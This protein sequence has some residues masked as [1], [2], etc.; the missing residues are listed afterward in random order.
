MG[1]RQK[2]VKSGRFSKTGEKGE[3]IT[4]AIL[5]PLAVSAANYLKKYKE[6]I[7]ETDNDSFIL[8]ETQDGARKGYKIFDEM[9]RDSQ[10][11]SDLKTRKLK[12]RG[13]NWKIS[14]DSENDSDLEQ[15]LQLEKQ[16]SPVY[17][18]LVTE[19]QEA[20]EYGFSITELMWELNE[21]NLV[22]L[23]SVK[24]H[25]PAKWGF[26][27][28]GTPGLKTV[29][30]PEP[31]VVPMERIIHSIFESPRGNPYGRSILLEVFWPWYWKKHAIL[32]WAIFCEKFGQPTI[33]GWHGKNAEDEEIN[34]LL[35]TLESIQSDSAVTLEEGWKIEFMESKRSGSDTSYESFVAY[36]DRCISKGILA[37]VL[38]TN[39]SQFGTRAHASEQKKVTDEVIEDDSLRI[40]EIISN[41]VVKYLA[42]WNYN[43]T[44]G[45]VPY[46]QIH[47]KDE[48]N[49]KDAAESTEIQQ[50]FMPIPL[51]DLYGVWG[52]N[53][54]EGDTVVV[55]NGQITNYS[56]LLNQKSLK[57]TNG[58]QFSKFS[59][60]ENGGSLLPENDRDIFVL[61]ES[62][63]ID[64]IFDSQKDRIVKAVLS[65]DLEKSLTGEDSF[66]GA[67]KV[68][69]DYTGGTAA[70][71]EELLTLAALEG[72]Y[73][74]YTQTISTQNIG[75]EY[76]F[77]VDLADANTHGDDVFRIIEP[78]E[79]IEYL[80]KKIVV[81]KEI[82][83]MIRKEVKNSAFY[84][85]KIDDLNLLKAIKEKM[86]Q[87]LQDGLTFS[88]WK[89]SV[90]DLLDIK[91]LGPYLRTSFNT[92]MFQALSV[93]RAKALYR[94][95]KNFPYWRYSSIL[96]RNTR[97]SHAAMH[98]FVARYD[99]PVW[100][101]WMAPNGYNCRCW[102]GIAT[103]EEVR[104]YLGQNSNY[105]E[106]GGGIKR[107]A[108]GFDFNP[109]NGMSRVLQ[110]LIIDKG[111]KNL[112]LNDEIRQL[113][114][115]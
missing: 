75:N 9:K 26:D 99:H 47:Y 58:D 55:F 12:I 1:Q 15:A 18:N 17:R 53:K 96:D 89:K 88:E 104:L 11:G 97:P 82:W 78:K 90:S 30:N 48:D 44:E 3:K 110:K 108:E 50:R 57:P 70:I 101:Y 22:S 4:P 83:E 24:G 35:T 115:F 94:N 10:V 13:L 6:F 25:D 109:A 80:K 103:P 36:C 81:D 54:P 37:A 100:S 106:P 29:E 20:L 52:W 49:S 68:L 66:S 64:D 60:D 65:T 74:V 107:P 59:T 34:D 38:T 98:N 2:V 14:V 40:Q 67:V 72:E 56:S 61:Q 42:K 8:K 21:N 33:I 73:S 87:A 45:V 86:L 31:Q 114:V 112:L 39:E 91:L 19:I 93:E 63:Y 71:W 43:F 27:E 113:E 111:K 28:N 5:K 7:K 32:F 46:L 51:D 95:V 77:E 23:P 16:L 41:T 92:N 102:V 76:R 105:L 84:I 62:D 79:A 85:S 69:R